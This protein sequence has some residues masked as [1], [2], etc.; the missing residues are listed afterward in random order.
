M[1]TN[2]KFYE[3][4][5]I[6]AIS[7]DG[8][9][10]NPKTTKQKLQFLKDTFKAEHGFNIVRV[11]EQNAFREWIQGLPSSFNI[12][13]ENYRI[14]ELAKK[15]GSLSKNPTEAQEDKILENYW[16]FITSKTYQLFRR[17]KIK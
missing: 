9:D 16:T 7:S 8:Y 14:L 2:N 1:T 11:G 3:K 12:P 4:L 17:N 13:F 10:S 6:R 5:I 15:S